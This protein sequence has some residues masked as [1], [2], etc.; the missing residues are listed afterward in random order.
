MVLDNPTTLNVNVYS[1]FYSAHGLS[2][3]INSFF[4]IPQRF[5]VAGFTDNDIDSVDLFPMA[6]ALV[7]E[8][9]DKKVIFPFYVY[10]CGE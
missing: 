5:M 1:T 10:L 2:S 4:D 9:R 3:H 8:T 7:R 6:E